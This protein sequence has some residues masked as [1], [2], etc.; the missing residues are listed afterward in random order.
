MGELD[1][2]CTV[3]GKCLPDP[4]GNAPYGICLVEESE[5]KGAARDELDWTNASLPQIYESSRNKVMHFNSDEEVESF[6]RAE[7]LPG[8]IG[9][10]TPRDLLN[11]TARVSQLMTFHGRCLFLMPQG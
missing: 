8:R 11:R 3:S 7:Q 1:T 4:E 2:C 9:V 6:W 5:S 10:E